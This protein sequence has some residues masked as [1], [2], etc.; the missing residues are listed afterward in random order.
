[1]MEFLISWGPLVLGI[2]AFWLVMRRSMNKYNNHIGNVDEI[3]GRLV[4]ATMQMKAAVDLNT[5]ILEEIK[6]VLLRAD[7]KN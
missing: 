5:K 4:D 2:G 1:M 3:N 6:N 7:R